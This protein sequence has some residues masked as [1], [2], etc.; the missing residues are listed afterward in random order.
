MSANDYNESYDFSS[1][2]YT[3]HPSPNFTPIV[4]NQWRE[5]GR[6]ILT[7]DKY[8]SFSNVESVYQREA[9]QVACAKYMY[10]N[11]YQEKWYGL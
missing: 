11:G 1:S 9:S 2:L 8:M 7:V 3:A 5:M 4:R 10:S 6:F